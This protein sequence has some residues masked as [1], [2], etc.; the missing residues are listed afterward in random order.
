MTKIGRCARQRDVEL[1]LRLSRALVA[2]R[3]VA[4]LIFKE[5]RKIDSQV[6]DIVVAAFAGLVSPAPFS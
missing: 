5:S 2:R 3:C 6:I 1:A 4:E